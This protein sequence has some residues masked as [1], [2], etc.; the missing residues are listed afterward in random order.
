MKIRAAVARSANEPLEVEE[1]EL[2]EELLPNEVL[3]RIE[4]AGIC[5]SDTEMRD[6]P[7]ENPMMPK[8]IVLGHE[9]AGIVEQVGQAVTALVPGDKVILAYH[10]DGEC[11]EC[12]RKREAYCH[13]F[14]KYNLSGLRVDGTIAGHDGETPVRTGYHQQSSWA[15]YSIATERNAIKVDTD[16]PIEYL[17]PLGCGFMTGYGAIRNSAKPEPGS[18]FV[19]FGMGAV[20]LGGVLAAVSAGCSTVVAV[21]LHQARLDLA[22]RAGA[23]VTINPSE[24]DVTAALRDIQPRGF[25]YSFEATGVPAV[26]TQAIDAI[27]TGGRATLVGLV[28]DGEVTAGFHPTTIV[29]DRT[30]HGVTMGHGDPE[31]TIKELVA[32]VEAGRLPL[33]D[34]VEFYTLDQVNQAMEDGATGKV[35]KPVMRPNL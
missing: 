25:N 2:T 4:S 12:Q 28:T 19:A 27:G 20:G 24:V 26:M 9:G 21:D 17:G 33:Q 34:L 15:T 29:L 23:T 11:P 14:F 18:S 7:P 3:V 10:S 6:L 30:I 35:F 22:K 31:G 1:L 8:P 32:H 16:I 5:H 13:R